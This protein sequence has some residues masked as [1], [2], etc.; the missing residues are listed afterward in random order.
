MTR[1]LFLLVIVLLA[2]LVLPARWLTIH[3]ATSTSFIPNEPNDTFATA[4]TL[5]EGYAMTGYFLTAGDH[6]YYRVDV[7]A[8]V[9]ELFVDASAL[10]YA[11][12]PTPQ[13]VTVRLYNGGHTLVA[14]D[15]SCADDIWLTE[16]VAAGTYFLLIE[17]CAGPLDID[18]PYTVSAAW[19]IDAG[20]HSPGDIEPNDTPA[21]AVAAAYGD[22]L[23][24]YISDTDTVDHYRFAA[25]AGD[26]IAL[27]LSDVAYRGDAV[28][29]L[30]DPAMNPVALQT[31]GWTSWASLPTAGNYV[32]R[33]AVPGADYDDGFID[34]DLLLALT[35]G[36]EPNNTRQTATDVAFGQLLNVTH[37]Y[38]CDTDWFRFQGRAGDVLAAVN[39][40]TE[41]ENVHL[42]AADG[43]S[44]YGRHVLPAD[45]VYYLKVEGFVNPAFDDSWCYE[46]PV[47]YPFGQSLWVSAAVDGLGGNAAIKRGDI[48]TR[49]DTAGQWQIVFDASDVGITQNVVAFERLP[50]GS[51]LMSL[52]G[53]QTVP[54]LGKVMPQDII[55]FVPTSLGDATAGTFQWFLDGSDVGLT[56]AGEKI[57]AIYYQTGIANPLRIS[58]RG[59]GAAPRTSGG[60]LKFA[61]EDTINLVNGVFGA[62]SAGTWR[63]GLDGSTVPGLKGEDVSSLTLVQTYP[64]RDSQLLIGLDSAFTVSGTKG[65][66]YD[67]LQEG[68]W[69]LA[70]THL[71]DKK[72]DGLGI[73]DPWT[74]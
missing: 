50:N 6:D 20:D 25:Q 57:D 24:G 53:P 22:H 2:A 15:T 41:V 28:L 18:S 31:D 23:R 12:N 7:P 34:Y 21:Q 13:P 43:T 5:P 4:V 45:G 60:M 65:T 27:A 59:A 19:N 44:L 40:E 11:Q 16:P 9:D 17:H 32:L 54:G 3:A 49:K 74:P 38:L 58:T 64:E 62:N 51:I 39:T 63:M 1:K 30:Y 42:Y 55:R 70:V 52:A 10:A 26:Q 71:T 48:A 37:D 68:T 61:D 69:Q 14:E 46:G 72:I 47:T 67:V 33:I 35:G 8:G 73:G 29:V 66:P 56:T 36:D